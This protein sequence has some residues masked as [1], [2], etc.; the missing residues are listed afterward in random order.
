MF[1]FS[2]YP[3]AL[4]IVSIYIFLLSSVAFYNQA[5][6]R[7]QFTL[8]RLPFGGVEFICRKQLCFL[9]L[10]RTQMRGSPSR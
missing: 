8:R 3:V 6:P 2:L 9:G 5:I 1:N 4:S 10:D 7:H